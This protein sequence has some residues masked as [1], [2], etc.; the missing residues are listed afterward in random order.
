MLSESSQVA[1]ENFYHFREI[2]VWDDYYT[3]LLLNRPKNHFC[4]RPLNVNN[5]SCHDAGC[6]NSQKKVA[7]PTPTNS[8]ERLGDTEKQLTS[9]I[10]KGTE[11]IQNQKWANK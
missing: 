11:T 10:N 1:S 8:T 3:Y 4:C 6:L 5:K 2:V 7:V 9:G